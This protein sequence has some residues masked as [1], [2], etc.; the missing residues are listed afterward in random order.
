MLGIPQTEDDEFEHFTD[1]EEFEGFDKER[2]PS[3]LK[4]QEKLPD[5]KMAKVPLHL[6]TNWDSFYMEMLMLAGLGVY[7][8]NFLAGKTKNTKL[9]QAWLSAHKDLLD[10]HFQIV[11]ESR[12]ILNTLFVSD[13]LTL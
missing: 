11:G 2:G 6:R 5:L 8:L 1:E 3:K 9:A 4:S 7:F 12:N 10:S 13:C